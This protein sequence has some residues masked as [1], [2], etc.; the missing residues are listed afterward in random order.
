MQFVTFY[1]I[2]LN[3]KVCK[4]QFYVVKCMQNLD[5]QL[6]VNS[7]T[8]ATTAYDILQY[9]ILEVDR[10]RLNCLPIDSINSTNYMLIGITTW[11]SN[12]PL[13][14]TNDNSGF[15]DVTKESVIKTVLDEAYTTQHCHTVRSQ[16]CCNKH[17]KH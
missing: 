6:Q 2:K 4:S 14:L 15:T 1:S 12:W 8:I 16:S 11:I 10:L 9:I 5:M 17:H 3:P 13:K 7:T